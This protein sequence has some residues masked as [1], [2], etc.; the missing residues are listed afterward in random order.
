MIRCPYCKERIKNGAVRCKHC[1]SSIGGNSSGGDDD[2]IRYLQNGFSKI[3]AECDVIE[4]RIMKQTGIV[5]IKHQYSADQLLQATKRI[6]SCVDKMKSDLIEWE[7]V[8][9]LT[10]QTKALF[11]KKAGEVYQRIESLHEMIEQR[12]P[13]WWEKV[14]DIFLSIL[15]KLLPFITIKLINGKESQKGIAA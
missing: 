7:S 14:S 9:K 2:G 5:F 3:I 1:H 11:N 13:T 12:E 6:D 15:S 10:H 8:N 4:D